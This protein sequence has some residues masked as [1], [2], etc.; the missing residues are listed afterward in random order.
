MNMA[1]F[2]PGSVAVVTGGASGIG[3]AAACR[4]AGRG[5]RVCLADLGA[6]RLVHAAR[7]VG[8]AAAGGAADVMTHETDVA[9]A[10]AVQRLEQ[11]VGAR[12]GGTDVLM[13]NAGVQPGSTVF[14]PADAWQR[15]LGVN[16]WGIVHGVQASSTPAPSKASRPHRAT[17]PTTSPRPA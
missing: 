15:V 1:A 9:D 14:G 13:N 8:E 2:T 4:F 7:Q 11:A 6:E 12:F 16:L 3:L 17:R 5:L 10:T